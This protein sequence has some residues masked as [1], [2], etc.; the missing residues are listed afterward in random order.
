MA[1]VTT[2]HHRQAHDRQQS[3]PAGTP[4]VP[5]ARRGVP[6]GRLRQATKPAPG[7][8]PH[9]AYRITWYFVASP[10]PRARPAPTSHRR[11]LDAAVDRRTRSRHPQRGEDEPGGGQV[12]GGQMA[13]GHQ[14]R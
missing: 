2:P 9:G 1:A 7:R 5:R 3:H 11:R 6:G 10:A 12:V 4:S 14:L 13:V 8:P